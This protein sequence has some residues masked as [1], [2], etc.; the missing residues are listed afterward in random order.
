M[1]LYDTTEFRAVK[2]WPYS[3]SAGCIIYRNHQGKTEVL[4]L[5]KQDDIATS[6]QKDYHLPK[7][8]VDV[9]ETLPEA[10]QREAQEETGCTI[11]VQTYAGALHWNVI[12]PVHHIAVEKTVHYFIALWQE[13]AAA[14]DGEYD[15]KHWVSIEDAKKLLGT[16]NPKGEDTII[17]RLEKFL[18]LT[19]ES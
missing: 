10:A 11:E 2:N 12:H 4:V 9:S 8:H 15:A 17:E 13:D 16:P 6:R 19:H 1:K 18:E 14:M 7:G 5:E 3:I